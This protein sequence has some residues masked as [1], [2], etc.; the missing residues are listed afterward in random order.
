LK[1]ILIIYCYTFGEDSMNFYSFHSY[2]GNQH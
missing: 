1:M 2:K